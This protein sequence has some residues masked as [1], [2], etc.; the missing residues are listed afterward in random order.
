MPTAVR[1]YNGGGSAFLPHVFQWVRAVNPIQ[2]LT[3]GVWQGH[4]GDPGSRSAI[5]SLQLEH[6]DVISFHSYGDP[7]EFEARIDELTP[8]DDRSSA[9]SIWPGVW[10][11]LWKESCRSPSGTTPA[12]TTGASSLGERRRICRG[13]PGSGLTPRFRRRGSAI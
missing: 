5:C 1:T 7:A 6:S 3:S 8:S 13:I 11:A 4:W 12:L 10:P 9:P 2:P